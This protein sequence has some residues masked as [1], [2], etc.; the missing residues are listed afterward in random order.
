[1]GVLEPNII[2]GRIG[3]RKKRKGERMGRWEGKKRE[4]VGLTL[5]GWSW[6]LEDMCVDGGGVV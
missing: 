6:T 3:A 2:I 1:M 4:K 5:P